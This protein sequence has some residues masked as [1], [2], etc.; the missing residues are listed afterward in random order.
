MALV[1]HSLDAALA[2]LD[3]VFLPLHL[4]TGTKFTTITYG[5][6]RVGNQAFADFVDA[7][8]TNLSHINNKKDPVPIL[9]G[10]FLGFHHPSGEIHIQSDGSWDS[11]PGIIK[12]P[13]LAETRIL[14]L[15]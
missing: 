5:M 9:P 6:P 14:I 7:H 11:C 1:G 15:F 12:S 2:R 3:A 13:L 8:V 4:P 10:E